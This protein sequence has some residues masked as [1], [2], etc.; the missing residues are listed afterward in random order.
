MYVLDTD[1]LGIL[2]RKRGPAF[3]RLALKLATVDDTHVYVAIVSF[4]EQIAGWTKYVKGSLDQS[5]VVFGYARLER[6]IRDFSEAQVLPYSTAAAEIFEEFRNRKVR[7][8]TMDLRN[9]A[10]AIAQRMTLVTRNILSISSICRS[11]N[12]KT[13]QCETAISRS[14]ILVRRLSKKFRLWSFGRR[15]L[16]YTSNHQV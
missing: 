3:D 13:G 11:S 15:P 9:A 8:A 7:I 10:I 1:H 16:M 5:R 12:L 2:Q 14:T 6:I 4:H